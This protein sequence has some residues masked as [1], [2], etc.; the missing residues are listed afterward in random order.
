VKRVK[1]KSGQDEVEFEADTA[2]PDDVVEIAFRVLERLKGRQRAGA[3]QDTLNGGAAAVMATH[4]DSFD[5]SLNS[6][7]S[8]LGGGS[9]R[10]ILKAA[11]IHLSLADKA[12]IFSKQDWFDRAASAHEWQR[13]FS[14]QRARDVRRMI[15]SK[16]VIE[17]NGG[18]YSV[19]AKIIADAKARLSID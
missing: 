12:P 15:S 7:I 6:F 5:Q 9:C 10:E 1:L 14:N 2:L 16:E 11:A 8:A 3:E 13:D 18:M 19:P 4:D 17:K